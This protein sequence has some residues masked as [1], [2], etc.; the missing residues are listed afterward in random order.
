MVHP[1]NRRGVIAGGAALLPGLMPG[2]ALAQNAPS[3][4][5]LVGKPRTVISDPPR[6]WGPGAPS[7]MFPD[8]DILVVD[9]SFSQLRL[10]QSN[11]HRIATGY[12]W[13][14]GPAW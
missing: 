5:A 13:A 1:L 8:P 4:N 9:P 6:E 10:S 11:I 14:E 3:P 2:L 12:Q 7:Q